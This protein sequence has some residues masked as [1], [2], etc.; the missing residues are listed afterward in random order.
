MLAVESQGEQVALVSVDPSGFVKTESGV[1]SPVGD[2]D[3][4]DESP[5]PIFAE[6]RFTGHVPAMSG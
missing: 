1:S 6:T 3:L 2:L 5:P 4:K